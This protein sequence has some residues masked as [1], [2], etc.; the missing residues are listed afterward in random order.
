MATSSTP[1]EGSFAALFPDNTAAKYVAYYQECSDDADD[2]SNPFKGQ[3]WRITDFA[4]FVKTYGELHH[5]FPGLYYRDAVTGEK[6]DDELTGSSEIDS[7]QF[8]GSLSRVDAARTRLLGAIK[9]ELI[10]ASEPKAV[11]SPPQKALDLVTVIRYRRQL[12]QQL[13]ASLKAY[14]DSYDTERIV[15]LCLG[16]LD[17]HGFNAERVALAR[18]QIDKE[19]KAVL[20]HELQVIGLRC[21]TNVLHDIEAANTPLPTVEEFD[22][23]SVR[24]H[25]DKIADRVAKAYHVV[26][27]GDAGPAKPT[28]NDITA[29]IAYSREQAKRWGE[30]Y[31]A[32]KQRLAAPNGATLKTYVT[33]VSAIRALDAH[34]ETEAKFSALYKICFGDA[35]TL[36]T[37]PLPTETEYKTMCVKVNTMAAEL[38]QTSDALRAVAEAEAAEAAKRAEEAAA[39]AEQAAAEAAEAEAEVA[40]FLAPTELDLALLEDGLVK[41]MPP[42]RLRQL[43][44]E[45]FAVDTATNLNDDTPR[46]ETVKTSADAQ[47]FIDMLEQYATKFCKVKQLFVAAED[48]A[49]EEAEATVF[50]EVTA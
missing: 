38:F 45:W 12:I 7:H 29:C 46:H 28:Q 23:A 47:K 37:T 14:E 9:A 11:P 5:V 42:A 13:Q 26:S 31:T 27:T 17:T 24:L 21:R 20:L 2:I 8:K 25:A 34:A 16:T 33:V 3:W 32:A 35:D 6:V 4:N 49:R 19:K 50:G 18:E 43:V 39:V 36:P 48:E 30:A 10:T 1:R 15:V 41:E 44:A 40:S 22:A